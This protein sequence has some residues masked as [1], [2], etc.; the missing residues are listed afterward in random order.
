MPATPK[1]AKLVRGLQARR[2]LTLPIPQYHIEGNDRPDD[3]INGGN[4]HK[5]EAEVF[6][7]DGYDGDGNGKS[8]QIDEVVDGPEPKEDV[9]RILQRKRHIKCE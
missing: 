7:G 5:L 4:D 9:R 3:E 6:P 1:R 8:Y 2:C